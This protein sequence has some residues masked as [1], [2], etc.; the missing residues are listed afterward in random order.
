MSRLRSDHQLSNVLMQQDRLT[1]LHPQSVCPFYGCSGLAAVLGTNRFSTYPVVRGP[2]QRQCLSWAG[3]EKAQR[4]P[5]PTTLEARERTTEDDISE[6][7][8]FEMPVISVASAASLAVLIQQ[9]CCRCLT[10]L[11]FPP[12]IESFG[13]GDANLDSVAPAKP[14]SS[15]THH[16][17]DIWVHIVG[18]GLG[19]HR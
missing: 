13:D 6:P 5:L 11:V 7:N 4:Y 14:R 9:L 19:L 2:L 3:L 17:M 8:R 12:R 18:A 15:S 10:K 1:T 16:D